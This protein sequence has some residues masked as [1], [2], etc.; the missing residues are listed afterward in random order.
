MRENNLKQTDLTEIFSAQS[1]V[2][3]V[4]AGK[5]EI[6]KLQA[7]TLAEKFKMKIEAFI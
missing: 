6:T 3:D 1:V 4:L 5:R 2:S 7:K